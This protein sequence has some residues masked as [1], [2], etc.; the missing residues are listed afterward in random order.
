MASLYEIDRKIEEILDRLY[1]EVNEET[2]EVPDDILFELSEM[3]EERKIKLDNIGAYIKNLEA[4]AAAIKAEEDN[5]KKRREA[6]SRKADR[7]REYISTELLSRNERKLETSRVAFS[8]RPS[9]SVNIVDK[10]KIPRE[11][12]KE[13]ITYDPDKTAIK[14]VLASGETVDGCVLIHKENLQIK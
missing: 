2:G 5:L 1:D 8:F 9:D 3:Q 12:M 14:K 7:L 11:F 10:E 4:E 6:K 13:K